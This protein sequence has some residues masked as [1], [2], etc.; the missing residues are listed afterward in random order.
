M[1]TRMIL[2]CFICLS[3]VEI[4]KDKEQFVSIRN[5]KQFYLSKGTG[6]PVVVFITGLGPT[7]EDFREIQ[8]KLSKTTR[9]IC[10]DRAGIGRSESFENERTLE[11]ISAELKE[12]TEAIGLNKPF[13]LVGHSRG[14]LIARYFVNKYPDKVSGLILID[15]ALPEHKWMKRELRTEIEKKEFDDYYNSFCTDS[16]KYSK[17]IRNEFKNAFTN[18]SAAVF[19]KGFPLSIPITLIAS[20]KKT[21]DKYSDA[22]IKMKEEFIKNYLNMNP[23]IKLVF[24]DKAGHFIY[25]D[26]PQLVI[27]EITS[28]IEQVK[29]K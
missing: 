1:S 28:V 14:G 23:Q 19:E 10:Y 7:M 27:D 13:V 16:T 8:N 6:E 12:L 20:T 24:T 3:F 29:A 25:D 4:Q 15:P 26:Q 11:N 21:E 2:L 5:K 18:D 17:I 9:T 22:E